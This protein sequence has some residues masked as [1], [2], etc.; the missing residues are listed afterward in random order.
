MASTLERNHSQPERLFEA[1]RM[2]FLCPDVELDV[3]ELP[4][5]RVY[6][7]REAVRAYWQSL[8][9]DVWRELTMK[10]E[11]IAE[12]D[13]VVVALVRCDGI[14]RGSGVPVEMRA[15]WVAT[16]RDGRVASARLTL[17]R[18]EAL[19]PLDSDESVSA[20]SR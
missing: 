1:T 20:L 18:D 15:A 19:D 3:S 6:R 2:G 4:D 5:G 13:D 10:V 14:G 9:A 16:I 17:D 11:A 8:H 7:G 12:R